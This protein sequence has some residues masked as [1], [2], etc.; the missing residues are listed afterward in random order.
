MNSPPPVSSYYGFRLGIKKYLNRYKGLL[1]IVRAIR[2]IWL[3]GPWSAMLVKYHQR[4]S[5]NERLPRNPNSLFDELD[6]DSATSSLKKNGYSTGIQVPELQVEE[7]LGYC[8][9][10][11]KKK[12]R[13]PHLTCEAIRQITHDPK[14]IEVARRYLGTEPVLYQ[15]DLYWTYPPSDEQR[16]QRMIAQKSRFHYDV[17]DFRSLVVFVYL[18]DVTADCG[19]HVVIEATHQKKPTWRLLS[20]F[21]ND[22][23]AEQ[24]YGDRIK[25]IT[26][27][28]GTGFFEDLTCYHK[29]AAGSKER[30]VLTI[31]YMLQRTPLL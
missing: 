11:N 16:H 27:K 2:A 8:R 21:L 4:F 9:S 5:R 12:H 22:K 1:Q 13:N 14:I 7:I 18:T 30:L 26:G 17:G 23:T 31:T 3:L 28:Q 6:V 25:V 24:Q 15:T 20:R 19:P 10:S 29:H